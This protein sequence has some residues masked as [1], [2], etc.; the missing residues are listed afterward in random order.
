MVKKNLY[1]AGFKHTILSAGDGR[2]AT[3]AIL[4]GNKKIQ[5]LWLIFIM[6]KLPLPF[7][8]LRE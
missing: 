8:A 3:L 1:A 7:P 2:P 4:P 5:N 6:G